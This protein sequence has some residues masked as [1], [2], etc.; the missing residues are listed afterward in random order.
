MKTPLFAFL[1]REHLKISIDRA[2]KLASVLT[3]ETLRCMQYEL[4]EQ[5]KVFLQREKDL[6]ARY[7]SLKNESFNDMIKRLAAEVVDKE[8]KQNLSIE[9]NSDPFSDST[10]PILKWKGDE[11]V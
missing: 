3:E 8:V 11:I 1:L 5:K 9:P 4:E 10:T 6:Q 7:E 2:N